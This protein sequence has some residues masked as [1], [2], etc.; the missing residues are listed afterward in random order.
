MHVLIVEDNKITRLVFE[1][2]IKSLGY[3][4]TACENAEN[5]LEACQSRFF[6]LII[7]DLGLP[8]MDGFEFCRRIRTLPQHEYSMI[9]V[10]TAYD[11][12]EDLQTALDAGADDYIIKPVDMELLR[13]RLLI[14]ER[15]LQNLNQQ[16][17]PVEQVAYP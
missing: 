2:L 3:E 6:P 10:V 15:Q 13:R 1:K 11:S 12:L 5:A 8:G 16:K 4:V 9:L 17:H 14:L 7:L